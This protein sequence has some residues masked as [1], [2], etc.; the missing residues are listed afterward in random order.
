MDHLRSLL[1]WDAY[2]TLL[3][4]LFIGYLAWYFVARL[5]DHAIDSLAAMLGVVFGAAVLQFV[6]TTELRAL[7]PVG[8]VLGWL[9]W[10][11][12]RILGGAAINVALT[13]QTAAEPPTE[14]G[15]SAK[16]A[17]LVIVWTIG[18]GVAGLGVLAVIN[19]IF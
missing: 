17:A 18:L 4:G 1:A 5:K 8:L 3:M 15:E 6:V 12:A 19:Y 9:L 7:Y 13:A 11:C 16:A 10:V 14:P 2:A